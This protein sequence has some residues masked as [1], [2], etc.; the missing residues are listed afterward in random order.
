MLQPCPFQL[1]Q[2]IGGGG[3]GTCRTSGQAGG[4]A[5]CAAAAAPLPGAAAPVTE[6]APA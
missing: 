2:P 5:C 3:T 6:A 4:Q 1:A